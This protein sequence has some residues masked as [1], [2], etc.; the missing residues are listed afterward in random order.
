MLIGLREKVF[1]E[2]PVWL[3]FYERSQIVEERNQ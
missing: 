2:T 1:E 3:V